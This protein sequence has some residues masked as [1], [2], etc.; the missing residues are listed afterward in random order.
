M[1]SPRIRE[2]LKQPIHSSIYENQGSVGMRSVGSV[3]KLRNL[4]NPEPEGWQPAPGTPLLAWPV[5]NC[6]LKQT[7]FGVAGG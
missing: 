3:P 1:F 5:G 2:R 7:Y 6:T 4:L